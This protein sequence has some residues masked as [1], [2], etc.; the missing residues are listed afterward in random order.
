MFPI[1]HVFHLLLFIF[2]K[3]HGDARIATYADLISWKHGV[4]YV[5]IG[6][7]K[8]ILTLLCPYMTR[9]DPRWRLLC[10]SSHIWEST[11]YSDGGMLMVWRETMIGLVWFYAYQP[12]SVIWC[13]IWFIHI[14]QIC[15]ICTKLNGTKY[16]YVLLIIQSNISHL[17]T[18][19]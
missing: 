16:C 4:T 1:Y 13:Q 6:R 14:Y 15:K 19:S 2:Q 10:L 12:L 9:I 17:F 11:A 8:R 3:S 18:H 7:R 5:L